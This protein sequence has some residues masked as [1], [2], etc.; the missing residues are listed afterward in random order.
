MKKLGTIV[1]ILCAVGV[2]GLGS[3]V[4]LR[5]TI[6]KVVLERGIKATT[7]VGLSIQRMHIGLT[8]AA[9]SIQGLKL[10][11][12]WGF[13]EEIMLDAPQIA[14]DVKAR[15][16]LRGKVHLEVVKMH[17]NEVI[18][19]KNAKGE[20]NI[21]A[22]KPVKESGQHKTAPKP[23]T[24]KAPPFQVDLLE[25]AIGKVVYKDYTQGN[26][27]KVQEFPINRTRQFRNVTRPE[28]V[29]TMLIFDTVGRTAVGRLADVHLQGLQQDL[30][31]M[32]QEGTESVGGVFQE[33]IDAFKGLF[34]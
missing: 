14:I 28:F 10:R 33:V 24:G 13:H 12:P 8:T 16:L 6:I 21:N 7:G 17:V 34:N 30:G 22:L 11:N 18:V 19:I 31:L 15:D 25:Y 1:L 20:V 9:V 27:P 5:N 29:V 26:P 2:V 3:I 32:L 4:I 23:A